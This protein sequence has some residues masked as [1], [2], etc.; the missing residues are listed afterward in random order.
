MGKIFVVIGKSATGKDTIYQQLMNDSELN[1][2]TVM[3]Y[4]TRPIRSSEENGREY[5]FVDNQKREELE[6]AG[7]IIEHRCYHTI[8]GPWHYFTANDGQIDLSKANYIM[9]QTLEGYKQIRDYFDRDA[10]VPVYIEVEDGIR[11]ERALKREREQREPKYTE[12]CRR[13]LADT[14]DFSEENIKALDIEKRYY[15][16]EMQKCIAEIKN[17]IL[18]TLRK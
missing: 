18:E 2:K 12:M 16:I 5:I 7:K 6:Q 4:T 10:V 1:L 9:I 14:E 11:L 8:Y 17:D 13:F 3:T 15:N